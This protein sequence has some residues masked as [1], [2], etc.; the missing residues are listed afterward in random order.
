MA[1]GLHFDGMAELQDFFDTLPDNLTDKADE[2][3]I[4]TAER[5]KSRAHDEYA[6]GETGN[7]RKGLRVRKKRDG[8]VVSATVINASPHSHLYES[9]SEMRQ[10]SA[11]ASRGRMPARAVIRKI[12][13]QER[14]EMREELLDM[15]EKETGALV[16]R[17]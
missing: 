10:T 3:V 15:V 14:R 17:G 2:I 16:I 7:L 11:G 5:A 9:G 4:S 1:Q 6:G 13:P 12:A 8:H